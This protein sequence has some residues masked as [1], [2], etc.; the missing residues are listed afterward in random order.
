MEYLV[1][2]AE[3]KQYDGNTINNIGI[4]GMVL[5]ERAALE[6]FR[7]IEARFGELTTARKRVFILAGTGNNGGDG[8]ALARLLCE[9]G[10][11]VTVHCVGN[12]MKASEQ[13]KQ[14][15]RILESFPVAFQVGGC[16]DDVGN[17]VGFNV[18]K[19]A[20]CLSYDILIDALFG[21]G[22][23]RD[24][25]GE[26]ARATECFNQATGFKISLDIPSGIHS[27][28]GNVLG[29]AIRADM[30]V[31]FGF[32]KR[33]LVLAPGKA[34][35]GEIIKASIG[36]SEKSFLGQEPSLFCYDEEPKALL[37]IRP[38]DGNKGTFGKVLLVAGSSKMAGAA[39]LAA[40]AAYRAGA[41]MVKVITAPDN[42]IVIHES[43]PEALYGT[44]EDLEESLKWADVIVAG[45]GLGMQPQSRECLKKILSLS[46]LPLVLDADAL[47][48]LAQDKELGDILTKQT[49]PIILSSEK[50]S[51]QYIESSELYEKR[52]EKCIEKYFA[53]QESGGRKVILTPHVGELSRLMNM[54]IATLKQDLPSYGKQ[55]AQELHAVVAAKDAQTYICR[56]TGSDCINLCGNSG[57][58]TA[59]SGDVLAGII[60]G[61]LAQGMSPF[62][63]AS[64][65]VYL[66]A[67][68]GD[69]VSAQIGEHAC[70]AGDIF[71][72]W[73]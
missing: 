63:A 15:R 11:D 62:D 54:P 30:T 60:G 23:T 53:K 64:V 8:L 66:H 34:Y 21:V 29:C 16:P 35:A 3:M 31:T 19:N 57:M 42:R 59:G 61:L 50:E 48:M 9:A 4:P 18:K 26:Y 68:A 51:V 58:A 24:I 12:V 1:T 72:I 71:K 67:K 33:G 7:V 17:V 44:Y 65:G 6:T 41:G 45:P 10:Y 22:L 25:E 47:N 37:P 36:I 28:T 27:D 40:R 32:L 5:M 73:I 70:M 43:V 46:N 14:Q 52:C 2:A 38:K 20:N 55:L 56:E 69:N 13:W 49:A 39:V